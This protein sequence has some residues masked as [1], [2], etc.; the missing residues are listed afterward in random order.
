MASMDRKSPQ[1]LAQMLLHLGRLA[2]GDVKVAGLTPAQWTV[3]RYFS[4]ANRFSR[5]ASAFASFHGTTRGTASQTIKSLV[6]GG[7]LERIRSK[8]D[9]RSAR[10]DLT[11]KG[12]AALAEDPFQALIDAIDR[13]PTGLAGAFGS[14]LEQLAFDVSRAR[15][16]PTFG[17]CE[18]CR[19]LEHDFAVG[20]ETHPYYCQCVAD[21][22]AAEELDLLCVDFEPARP[23]RLGATATSPGKPEMLASSG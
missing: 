20:E 12:R 18:Q 4:S 2:H 5:T 22:L 14:V 17:T 8:R 6:A 15:S 10:L 23:R 13:L 9:G 1:M 16:A 11:P 3:L 7:N 19:H 21:A